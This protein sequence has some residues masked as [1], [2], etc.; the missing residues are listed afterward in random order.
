MTPLT[1]ALP[2]C[3][4]LPGWEVDDAPLHAA[5]RARGARVERPVWDAPSVDWAAFDAV[6]I[7]TTWDY[8]EKLPAFLRWAE[9]VSEVSRLLNPLAVTR[10]NTRK[11]YLRDLEA[12]G[13]R[14][15][16]TVWLAAGTDAAVLAPRALQGL[17]AERG[18]DR[19]FLKP[20]VGATARETLRFGAD[21]EG[22]AAASA[23]LAR[24]LPREGMM[25]QP[26]LT[27]VETEGEFSA[28]VI[29]GRV[30][31]CVQKVPVAGDYRV[32]DDF[33]ASD[34]PAVL[35][36]EERRFA[37]GVMDLARARFPDLL[38]ARVDFLR[39]AAGRPC[40]NELELVEPSLFFRHAPA[41]A[42]ALA[43][44][45]ISRASR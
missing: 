31:H 1:L 14:I 42:E 6:L 18:W 45:L 43:D 21:A 11:T 34:G 33:G 7:R 17:L 5:L 38:Y 39:D 20:V 32:Q 28:I 16:P 22:I 19:A 15:A 35:S 10:W 25:L 36:D 37:A 24:L 30:T 41:A 44:A 26:Y 12:D 9:R 3:A 29:D 23:H 27:R 4:N 13:A 40:L 8:Q 2:T